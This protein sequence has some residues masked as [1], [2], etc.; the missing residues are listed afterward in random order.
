MPLPAGLPRCAATKHMSTVFLDTTRKRKRI[1]RTIIIVIFG[2]LLAGLTLLVSSIFFNTAERPALTYAHA[3]Q[4]YHFYYSPINANT[5]AITFD[6][7]PRAK[8][9]FQLMDELER[10]DAPATFFYVGQN[11][12]F[13]PHVVAE[14]AK[15]G[16]TIG[17]HSFTHSQQVQKSESRLALELHATEYLLSRITGNSTFYYRPPYLMG[18]GIDPTMNP[19]VPVPKDVIWTMQN[20]Y[21][22]VGADIDPEDWLA[23]SKEEV[24]ARVKKSLKESHGGRILLLHED[25]HTIDAMGDIVKTIRAAGY[26]I[27]PL[28][29]LLTPPKELALTYPLKTGSTDKT[30]EGQ[31]SL[32]QWFLYQDGH[33]D[34]YLITGEFG[35]ATESALIRFQIKNKLIDGGSAVSAAGVAGAKTRE[36]LNAVS[37]S[38]LTSSQVNTSEMRGF[39]TESTTGN[40]VT[41]AYIYLFP[42][43][44]WLLT[45]MVRL[46][47]FLVFL[48]C[49]VVLLFLAWGRIRKPKQTNDRALDRKMRKHGVSVLIPAYNE[50]ENIQATIES[51][52][53][54]TH[55]KRE[56]LVIDDGSTDNTGMLVREVIAR[57]P[58]QP[59][60]LIQ[61]ENG[62][63]ARA[64][65]HGLRA[66]SYEICAVVDADA[67]LDP[68]ALTNFI[69]HFANPAVAAV[70][71]KVC[72]TQNTYTLD[73]FQTLEYAIGQNI[74][75]R[76]FSVLGAVGVVPGPAGAWR[77]DFLLKTGGFSTDTLV[78]DQDM[79]LT[80]LRAGHTIVY[81]ER[82]IAYTETPHSVKNFLKQRF[83]WVYGTMQCFWKHKRVMVERPLSGMTLV[84]MPNIFIFNI[85]LPLSYPFAD[86]ALLVGLALTDWSGLI[87]PFALF[88]LFDVVYAG[89]GVWPEKN[90]LRLLSMVPLQRIVYRQL[91]YYTVMRGV[92]RSIEGTGSG[93]NKFA[94]MGETQ[95][96]YFSA[97]PAAAAAGASEVQLL[98]T[99]N[100][101]A[102]TKISQEPHVVPEV[103]TM[104]FQ[105]PAG[106]SEESTNAQDVVALS[107]SSRHVISAGEISSPALTPKV[108]EGTSAEPNTNA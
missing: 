33:L 76:A 72:T 11:V 93:W 94:K 17:N 30:T 22:P 83:R 41:N 14:A 99:Q 102:E 21:N 98:S 47:L 57:H 74:D 73:L 97:V 81:E 71:G 66:A 42:H 3:A 49:G 16:F 61:V 58:K 8:S 10:H 28:E 53:Q 62:G 92:V 9:S 7:G 67:V 85:I 70:A 2:F 32:L 20:G 108:F 90:R 87:V 15:R 91:L 39:L 101:P 43:I 88:T 25:Q 103:V 50:Q 96:F 89:I 107:E 82:A 45:F 100:A 54:S 24:L 59:I 84:V 35:P 1:F 13:Y 46:T 19:Y 12:L 79:T 75:K 38:V 51:V 27:V 78:E 68:E 26:T 5:I 37:R 44:H 106:T 6:D 77:R 52:L 65:N 104:S 48:R 31:V 63:K 80:M 69:R 29:D 36:V 18:I 60:R 64:L 86:S 105:G 55:T 56:I 23:T 95:R 34:P 40:F 4:A